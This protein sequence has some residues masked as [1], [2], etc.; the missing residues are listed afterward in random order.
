[1]YIYV[2]IYIYIYV[3]FLLPI[4]YAELVPRLL[5]PTAY[6]HCL[7]AINRGAHW[8]LNMH[9]AQATC[10]VYSQKAM[11]SDIA[12]YTCDLKGSNRQSIL[13]IK[14]ITLY[15]IIYIHIYIYECLRLSR[16]W[17]V[18]VGKFS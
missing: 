7:L 5:L 4:V 6:C 12:M 17:W 3:C 14:Y 8:G 10:I 2:Y 18:K 16:I 1:M 11:Y 13:N 9:C 15:V